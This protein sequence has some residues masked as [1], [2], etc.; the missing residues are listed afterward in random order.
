MTDLRHVAQLLHEAAVTE[1][2]GPTALANWL[3]RRIAEADRDTE[4]E[5][6][7]RRLESDSQAVQVITIHRSKGLEF[8]VVLCPFP[9]DGWNPTI[10]VPVFHDQGGERA[11]DVGSPAAVLTAHR[12]MAGDEDQGESLRLLYVALDAGPAPSRAVVGRDDPHQELAALPA[13][14]RPGA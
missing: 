9:W 12:K 13:A 10:E 2:V 6:R 14:L 5:E 1:G 7:T 8:P 4:S 11:V 3:G